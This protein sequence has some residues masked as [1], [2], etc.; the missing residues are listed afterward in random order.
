[1]ELRSGGRSKVGDAQGAG[2]GAGADGSGEE[3]G[4]ACT[5]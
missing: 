3:G 2:V 1:M 5:D 4:D